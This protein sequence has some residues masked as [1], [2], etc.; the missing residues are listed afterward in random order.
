MSI[1]KEDTTKGLKYGRILTLIFRRKG[2]SFDGV[3]ESKPTDGDRIDKECFWRLHLGYHDNRWLYKKSKLK[4]S[5][6]PGFG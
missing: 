1:C 6:A 2:I 3:V 5:H 4:T